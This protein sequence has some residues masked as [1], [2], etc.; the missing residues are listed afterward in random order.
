MH[1]TLILR[2]A[3]QARAL[4]DDMAVRAGVLLKVSGCGGSI[5]VIYWRETP[6]YK[7]EKWMLTEVDTCWLIRSRGG[8]VA[9]VV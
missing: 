6:V 2:H 9:R 5:P 7:S 8:T 3:R 4:L 1:F